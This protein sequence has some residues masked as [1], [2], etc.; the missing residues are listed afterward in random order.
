MH[1]KRIRVFYWSSEYSDFYTKENPIHDTLYNSLMAVK[2]KLVNFKK[3]Y[4]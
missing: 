2:Y 3:K 4:V 1:K